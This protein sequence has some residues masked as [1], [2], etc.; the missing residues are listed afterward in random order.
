MSPQIDIASG[1]WALVGGVSDQTTKKTRDVHD[2]RTILTPKKTRAV[3]NEPV[4]RGGLMPGGSARFELAAV[5]PGADHGAVVAH[6]GFALTATIALF[7]IPDGTGGSPARPFG[8]VRCGVSE[9]DS[10][11]DDARLKGQVWA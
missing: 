3:R 1:D 5:R 8:A 11:A 10:G 9:F 7:P 6:R 2:Q 4:S